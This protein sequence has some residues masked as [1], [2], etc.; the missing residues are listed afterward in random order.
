MVMEVSS[1]VGL[2]VECMQISL[3]VTIIFWISDFLV[4]T[5]LRTAFGGHLRF[6]G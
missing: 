2:Y 5:V 1:I 6:K 3:P 4:C